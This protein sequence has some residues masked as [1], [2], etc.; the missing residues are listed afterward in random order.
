M[1]LTLC[2]LRRVSWAF[3]DVLKGRWNYEKF[4]GRQF[5]HLTVGVI[6]WGRLGKMYS[7]YVKALGAKVIV[8]DPAYTNDTCTYTI[9]NF[10]DLIRKSDII[11][12]HIH[13]TPENIGLFS[14]RVLG[15]A[16]EEVIITNTSRGEIVDEIEMVNFL[17]GK[18]K[19]ILATDVLSNELTSK[20]QSP[21]IDYAK[22]GGNVLITPHIG[23]MTHEAQQIAY[24]RAADLLIEALL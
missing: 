17:K 24:H 15:L 14:E 1:A 21:L 4:I 6:G 11:S 9:S 16:K 12:I 19:A 8:C 18:P 3:S 7:N 5:D 2:A 13:A 10:D 22:A 23:G 20:W